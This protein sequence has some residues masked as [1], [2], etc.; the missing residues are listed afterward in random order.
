MWLECC[1]QINFIVSDI[2]NE[3]FVTYSGTVPALFSEGKRMV[4]E[5]KLKDKNFFGGLFPQTNI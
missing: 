1:S 3:I 5:G 2:K 4:A